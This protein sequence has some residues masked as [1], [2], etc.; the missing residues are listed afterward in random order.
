MAKETR[1]EAK[2]RVNLGLIIGLVLLVVI[3]IAVSIVRGAAPNDP[4]LTSA[5]PIQAS[6]ATQAS[7]ASPELLERKRRE[8]GEPAGG[9]PPKPAQP[10]TP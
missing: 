2:P 1:F 5:P 10:Y 4:T 7:V 3:G 6:P 9:A 8:A